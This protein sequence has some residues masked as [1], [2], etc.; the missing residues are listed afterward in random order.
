MTVYKMSIV[1]LYSL[2]RRV[3]LPAAPRSSGSTRRPDPLN[4]RAGGFRM[5][6]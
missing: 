2:L 4:G 1:I 5:P 3:P 6:A